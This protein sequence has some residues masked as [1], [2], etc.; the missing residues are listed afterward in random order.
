[1]ENQALENL[2]HS[3]HDFLSLPKIIPRQDIVNASQYLKLSTIDK[4]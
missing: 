1:M 4:K 3:E 2:R